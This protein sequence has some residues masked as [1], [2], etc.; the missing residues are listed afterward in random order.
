MKI[1]VGPLSLRQSP[2]E[3]ACLHRV[4]KSVHKELKELRLVTLREMSVHERGI[5]KG[6]AY[7]LEFS[8]P[9]RTSLPLRRKSVTSC[10]DTEP[11]FDDRDVRM[12]ER[13]TSHTCS[14]YMNSSVR[15][16]RVYDSVFAALDIECHC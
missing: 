9:T 14:E 7:A 5:K 3:A 1:C 15:A 6:R 10:D 13:E 12:H 4:E 16:T 11:L 2:R 8:N